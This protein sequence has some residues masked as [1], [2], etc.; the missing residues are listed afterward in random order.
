MAKKLIALVLIASV[1]FWIFADEWYL[2]P[3]SEKK[4]NSESI[5]KPALTNLESAS[6]FLLGFVTTLGV[7]AAAY[8]VNKEF[9][10]GN[11]AIYL[12]IGASALL[13]TIFNGLAF[14][15]IAL[16]SKTD[17]ASNLEQKKEVEVKA[18]EMMKYFFYGVG[19]APVLEVLV[20]G[21]LFIIL[22]IYLIFFI[23]F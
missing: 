11:E 14:Y 2:F 21:V 22:I 18:K 23:S 8:L 5:K 3:E 19:A 17:K 6:S 4:A 20:I 10:S 12:A 9:N 16:M 13:M 7:E 1:C 15:R